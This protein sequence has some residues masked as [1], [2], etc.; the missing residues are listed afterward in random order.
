MIETLY[1]YKPPTVNNDDVSTPLTSD[2]IKKNKD[3]YEK[4]INTISNKIEYVLLGECTHGTE[5]FYKI[6]S[7]MTKIFSDSLPSSLCVL[8][9]LLKK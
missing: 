3:E 9:L 7:N 5:E 6:R 1:L 8:C 2:Q 4:L